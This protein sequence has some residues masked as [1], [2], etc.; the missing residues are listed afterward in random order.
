MRAVLTDVIV[1]V[2]RQSEQ[3]A[4]QLRVVWEGGT[5]TEHSVPLSRTGSHTRCTDEDTIALVRQ[6]AEQYPD[7][8]IAAILAAKDA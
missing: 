7:K 2:D 4:A 6:L 3:H 8:Q 5:V 1:T